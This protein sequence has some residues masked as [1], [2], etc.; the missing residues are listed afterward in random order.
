M[1]SLCSALGWHHIVRE[2]SSSLFPAPLSLMTMASLNYIRMVVVHS[3]LQLSSKVPRMSCYRISRNNYSQCR[4][5]WIISSFSVYIF[6]TFLT[7]F[8]IL[9]T[10]TVYCTL[11]QIDLLPYN[12]HSRRLQFVILNK[13]LHTLRVEQVVYLQEHLEINQLQVT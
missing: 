13:G 10:N 5:K 1:H 12:I 6:C 9:S 2:H 4:I 3:V 11:L 7:S 8:T